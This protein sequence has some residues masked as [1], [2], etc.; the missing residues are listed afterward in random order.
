MPPL[1]KSDF[2]TA[3]MT[4]A[5]WESDACVFVQIVRSLGLMQTSRSGSGPSGWVCTAFGDSDGHARTVVDDA[6]EQCPESACD[7]SDGHR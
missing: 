7:A 2:A 5:Q 4:L 3:P 1:S 6:Q